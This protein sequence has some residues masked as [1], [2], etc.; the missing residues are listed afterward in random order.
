MHGVGHV[1]YTNI[2]ACKYGRRQLEPQ[3]AITLNM[4]I[5]VSRVL[6]GASRCRKLGRQ[7]AP[8]AQSHILL[9]DSK[10]HSRNHILFCKWRMQ[11]AL[12]ARWG[13][14]YLSLSLQS[15]WCV[16]SAGKG[17]CSTWLVE[18][19]MFPMNIVFIFLQNFNTLYQTMLQIFFGEI[20]DTQL[21]NLL[22][23]R[24]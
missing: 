23:Y 7:Q 4:W 11:A 13:G 8:L 9:E 20:P 17:F 12:C 19:V 18:L 15:H 16:G 14:S 21:I 1:H 22:L 6:T 10:R 5:Q 3:F 2:F 24:V